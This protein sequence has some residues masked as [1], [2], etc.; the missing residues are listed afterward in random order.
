MIIFELRELNV[1]IRASTRL[2][3]VMCWIV[4]EMVEV[5]EHRRLM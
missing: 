1:L 2:V 3:S 4:V 5:L